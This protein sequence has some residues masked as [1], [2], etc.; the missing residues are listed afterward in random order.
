MWVQGLGGLSVCRLAARM[1]GSDAQRK[2]LLH[3][4]AV[5]VTQWPGL[6]GPSS[7][8]VACLI[9]RRKLFRQQNYKP[10]S[11]FK[12]HL[13]LVKQ[14]V[15]GVA[16]PQ[17]FLG[18][19]CPCGPS[20]PWSARGS[21]VSEQSSWHRSSSQDLISV[22]P[23]SIL[24]PREAVGVLTGTAQTL[25][26]DRPSFKPCCAPF[27]RAT[28]TEP[29]GLAQFLLQQHSLENGSACL[30]RLQWEISLLTS[31]FLLETLGQCTEVPSPTPRQG[32]D[33]QDLLI[34]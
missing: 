4:R 12:V 7:S 16:E 8:S 15:L 28:L 9:S 18:V 19:L 33:K 27:C 25:V 21:R 29:L 11:I 24:C 10:H 30:P 22:E 2:R 5:R 26:S 17:V 14:E 32:T 3:S 23:Q 20:P 13:V 6:A 1:H 31:S 34:P